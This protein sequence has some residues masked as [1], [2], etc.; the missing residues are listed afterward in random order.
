MLFKNTIKKIGPVFE[1]K[2]FLTDV[3]IPK[4]AHSFKSIYTNKASYFIEYAT[5]LFELFVTKSRIILIWQDFPKTF[6]THRRVRHPVRAR[7]ARIGGPDLHK[8]LVGE[9]WCFL[10]L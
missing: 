7:G 9:H 8:V 10:Y 3:K 4:A 6:G 2:C 5:L 1:F